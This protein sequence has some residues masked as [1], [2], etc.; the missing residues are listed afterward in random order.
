MKKEGMMAGRTRNIHFLCL[1]LLIGTVLHGERELYRVSEK[2]VN[3]RSGPGITHKALGTLKAGDTLE[4]VERNGNWLKVICRSGKM[5]GVEGYVYQNVVVPAGTAPLAESAAKKKA[6]SSIPQPRALAAAPRQ[7]RVDASDQ[8][9]IDEIQRKMLS[10]SLLFLGLLKQ[11]EPKLVEEKKEVERVPRVKVVQANT[12]VLDGFLGGAKVIHYPYLNE[13]FTVLEEEDD[14]YKIELPGKREG[15][16]RK[17]AVQFF[18]EVSSRPVV[19]FAGIDK[20]EATRFLA[21]LA[22]VYN[23]IVAGKN[24]ADRIVS[25]YDRA[26]I[27]RTPLH[28]SYE[29]INKYYRLSSQFYEKYRIDE[30]LIFSGTKAGFLAK[31]KLW[32]E[33]LL[34]TETTGTLYAGE[35]A[36][37]ETGGGKHTLNLGGSYQVNDDLDLS[38]DFATQKEVMLEVFSQTHLGGAVRYTGVERLRL[39]LNAGIDSYSSPDNLRSD[40]SNF[41]LGTDL[42]YQLSSKADLSFRYDMR[43]FKYTNDTANDFLSHRMFAGLSSPL[44][45]T[46]GV[47]CDLLFETQSGDL[48]NHK[49]THFNPVLTLSARRSHGFFKTRLLLD[50]YSFPGLAQSDY[51]KVGGDLDWGSNRSDFLLGGFLKSH[52]ENEVA[53]Y[54]RLML[55]YTRNSK[56]F[57]SRFAVSLFSNFF[58]NEK[59]NSYS[60]FNLELSSLGNFLTSSL[61]LLVKLWHSPGDA[62]LG[63]TVS[64]HVIDLY[65]KVGFNMKYLVIG[66]IIGVHGNLVFSGDGELI[67]RDGNLLRFGGFADLDL[68]VSDRLKILGQGTFEFGNVYTNNY[69][70]FNDLTGDILID[71]T[72]LRH[73]TTLQINASAQYQL[74]SGIYLFARGGFYLVK[75]G[76]EPIPGMYP[77]EAN[78]RFYLVGGVN[79]RLN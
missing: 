69:T 15:W 28:A 21:Q 38:L 58:P 13:T 54:Q 53:D 67:E 66:P 12:P 49:F 31:L 23:Q 50:S 65:W 43:N 39:A 68:P 77:V 18:R 30:S 59:A 2:A 22:E 73:P 60:D 29:K 46:W 32:G 37:E 1:F 56:D 24:V 61:N 6:K 35:S 72:F 17:S 48:P 19:K 78:S 25:A 33:L 4:F 44:S 74:N 26:S 9:L 51:M 11:M 20:S 36:K 10:D 55:R 71:G 63:Q 7:S 75:T 8:K 41:S 5:K 62:D 3:F 34:G 14:H 57:K 45:A 52:A 47:R 16:V 27:I 42:A 70:G 64:P 40:F 79:F 76:F